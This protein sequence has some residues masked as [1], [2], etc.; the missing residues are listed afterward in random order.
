MLSATDIKALKILLEYFKEMSSHETCDE[1]EID[2]IPVAE[3]VEL[4]RAYHADEIE[5][6]GEIT[7]A[8]VQDVVSAS[9]LARYFLDKFES[10]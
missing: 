8:D 3:R 6:Y 1:I 10:N 4:M 5:D 7:E 9:G 2:V